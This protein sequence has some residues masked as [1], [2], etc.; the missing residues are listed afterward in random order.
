MIKYAK[1]VCGTLQVPQ[2]YPCSIVVEGKTI[3][4]PTPEQYTA[5][6]YLPLEETPQP[7]EEEGKVAVATYA[8]NDEGTAIVQSWHLE[9]VPE[10][11]M[12]DDEP[13]TDTEVQGG[14]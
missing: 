3:Y 10:P 4:N 12:P 13:T 7:D 5:A 1:I 14:E 8:V 6:G 11:V 9:D 2:N